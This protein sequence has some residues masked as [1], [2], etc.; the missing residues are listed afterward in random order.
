MRNRATRSRQDN[1]Q[2]LRS[3][4]RSVRINDVR[5]SD[6]SG[7]NLD[8]AALNAIELLIEAESLL[9]RTE[10]EQNALESEYGEKPARIA[11]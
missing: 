10:T 11:N 7:I 9:T 3:Q 5:I 6:S 1:L 2:Q 4:S 8:I